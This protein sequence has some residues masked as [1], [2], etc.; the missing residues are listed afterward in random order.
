LSGQVEPG[1]SIVTTV[2]P[3]LVSGA[4]LLQ[5]PG[6]QVCGILLK[7]SGLSLALAKGKPPCKVEC[8]ELLRS[9]NKNLEG[10]PSMKLF[11]LTAK[12]DV[13]YDCNYGFVIRAATPLEARMMANEKAQDEG[14]IWDNPELADCQE[15]TAEGEPE[16][17]LGDFNRG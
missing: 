17:I 14:R 2:T 3:A 15:L 6:S 5:A 13:G 7:T 8:T 4:T 11:L 1:G 12:S 9:S 10:N 16:I